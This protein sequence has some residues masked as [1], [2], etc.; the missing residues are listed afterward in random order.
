M[1]NL[2]YNRFM[3]NVKIYRQFLSLC[4]NGFALID[5]GGAIIEVNNTLCDLSGRTKDELTSADFDVLFDAISVDTILRIYEAF[6]CGDICQ[7]IAG[8][9]IPK[10]GEA[11]PVEIFVNCTED[12]H[13]L[14]IKIQ[15]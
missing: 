12:E 2:N 5:S 9:L 4:D 13:W 15:Q 6:E 11:V 3:H 14:L 8:D 7:T 1:R 10:N